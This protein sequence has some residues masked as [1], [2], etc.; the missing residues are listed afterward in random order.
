[1]EKSKFRRAV[2]TL[3]VLAVTAIGVT[4]GQ[5]SRCSCKDVCGSLDP[6]MSLAC[7]ACRASCNVDI[8]VDAP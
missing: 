4:P 5:A 2:W 6:T 7:T 1:M 8:T 3:A